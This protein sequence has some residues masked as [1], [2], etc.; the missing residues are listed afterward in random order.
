MLFFVQDDGGETRRG[1]GEG[2]TYTLVGDRLTFTHQYHLSAGEEVAS[3]D[4]APL[5]MSVKETSEAAREPCRVEIEGELDD[6]PFPERQP[7]GVRKELGLLAFH[8]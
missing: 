8:A 7:D 1:S 3:L 6:H 4:P 5:R 2:G